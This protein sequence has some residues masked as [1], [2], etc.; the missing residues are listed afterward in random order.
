MGCVWDIG[1]QRERIWVYGSAWLWMFD[2]GQD[3][4]KPE[5]S[6]ECR[7]SDDGE[8]QSRKDLKRRKRKRE[9]AKLLTSQIAE[10]NDISKRRERARDTGAGD[11]ISAHE[12]NT[13]VG[14]KIR[15]T[16]GASGEDAKIISLDRED[17]GSDSDEEGVTE[18][19]GSTSLALVHLRRGGGEGAV[20]ENGTGKGEQRQKRPP[21]WGTYKYRPILGIVPIGPS[22]MDEEGAQ[23]RRG[24]EVA[25][26]ERP[27]FDVDLPGRYH[28]DQEWQEKKD[29][30]D[31]VG[32]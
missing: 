20:M 9:K 8:P 5:A 14:A 22:V 6:E 31:V 15:K 21:F 17:D 3:L 10:G 29:A 1:A 7:E 16:V 13:G 18:D 23:E 11:R 4:P 27:M 2:L 19:E 32:R 12:L 30:G 28:G 25:I 24:V 26:V